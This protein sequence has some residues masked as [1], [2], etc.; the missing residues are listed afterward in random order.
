[1]ESFNRDELVV[2][3]FLDAEKVFD[4]VWHDGFKN[5]IFQL[6]LVDGFLSSKIYPK[7]GVP[8]DS[9]LSPLLFLV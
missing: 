7:K 6:G 5:K 2:A 4:D 1:M 8:Q 3:F 9:V